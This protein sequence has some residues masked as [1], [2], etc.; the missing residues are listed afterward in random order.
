MNNDDFDLDIDLGDADNDFFDSANNGGN[1]D[2]FGQD[3]S[4]GFSQ[5]NLGGFGNNQ[6]GLDDQGNGQYQIPNDYSPQGGFNDQYDGNDDSA[7][8]RKT[9]IIGAIGVIIVLLTVAIAG[10]AL[11]GG[12]NKKSKPEQIVKEQVQMP[13]SST[14]GNNLSNVGGSGWTEIDP[15]TGLK[16]SEPIPGDF[17]PTNV[18]HYVKTTTTGEM[19]IKSI[20]TGSISG[21]TGTYEL[22]IPYSQGCLLKRGQYFS[23]TYRISEINGQQ[24]ISDIVY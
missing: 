23:I 7:I 18:R 8:K 10:V 4:N 14:G 22:E 3:D 13:Q 21:L 11:K 17:T 2:G 9:L 12:K 15:D 6:G 20:V 24:I 5:D 19:E 16:F 1:F